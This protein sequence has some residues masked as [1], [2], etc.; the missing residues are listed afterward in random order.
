MNRRAERLDWTSRRATSGGRTL[1]TPARTAYDWP[2]HRH[3][4]AKLPRPPSVSARRPGAQQDRDGSQPCPSPRRKSRRSRG[5]WANVPEYFRNPYVRIRRNRRARITTR[6]WHHE[7]SP[8]LPGETADRDR[9]LGR[10]EA[11]L[12][13]LEHPAD[14]SLAKNDHARGCSMVARMSRYGPVAAD[15]NRHQIRGSYRIS[16]QAAP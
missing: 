11:L 6:L 1:G 15:T 14:R 16:P 9:R 13:N 7:P 10:V 8:P 5:S 3:P 2:S 4:N 12:P